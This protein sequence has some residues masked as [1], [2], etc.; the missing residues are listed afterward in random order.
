MTVDTEKTEI[1]K[2]TE[3]TERLML[4]FALFPTG[5]ACSQTTAGT[6]RVWEGWGNQAY[7]TNSLG[8]LSEAVFKPLGLDGIHLRKLKSLANVMTR[9][10]PAIKNSNS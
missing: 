3:N 4:F 2:Y 1:L 5:K 9:L 7:R 10:L 8:M 6:N